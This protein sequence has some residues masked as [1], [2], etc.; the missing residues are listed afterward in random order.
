M[1]VH[2]KYTKEL[3]AAATIK[4]ESVAGV[5]R[6][7][8]LKAS[9]GNHSHISRRLKSYEI[10]TSHFRDRGGFKNG[11]APFPPK[12]PESV[13]VVLSDGS[14]RTRAKTLRKALIDIRVEYCCNICKQLPTWFGKP[15]TLPVDH[16][17]GN[18]LDNRREN[19]R[20]L[21]PNCHS[22]TETFCTG[23]RKFTRYQNI[24]PDCGKN[25]RRDSSR[26]K[27]CAPIF[28]VLVKA[29]K[30]KIDWPPLDTLLEAKRER[31]VSALARNLGVSDSAIHKRIRQF[32]RV[33]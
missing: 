9:G 5:L 17:N 28:G 11:Q 16:V 10:D 19:L 2:Q 18:W 30:T 6:E 15:L 22:Q 33:A 13:L 3:L 12:S 32:G 27:Q 20:F 24:C 26:C 31:R 21:C 7:L 1:P 29:R 4:S 14:T 25:I 8:G 23:N